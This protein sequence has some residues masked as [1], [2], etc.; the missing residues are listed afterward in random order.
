MSQWTHVAGVIRVDGLGFI[1]GMTPVDEK[2]ALERTLGLVIGYDTPIG[3]HSKCKLPSGSEGSLQYSVDIHSKSTSAY[4]GAITIWGDLIDYDDVGELITWFEGTLGL[5]DGDERSFPF[6]V[7]DA[8][9]SID[10]EFSM[11]KVICVWDDKKLVTTKV[12]RGR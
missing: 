6:L 7:R 8:V 5:F 2:K 10:L 12:K 1:L 11:E 3:E 4:R 9:M